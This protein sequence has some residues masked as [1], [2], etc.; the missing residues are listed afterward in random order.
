MVPC[1]VT[2]LYEP[3]ALSTDHPLLNSS[4]RSRKTIR[5]IHWAPCPFSQGRTNT[6]RSPKEPNPTKFNS[7]AFPPFSF[8]SERL[9]STMKE[10]MNVCNWDTV[11][12]DTEGVRE[13]ERAEDDAAEALAKAVFP[14]IKRLPVSPHTAMAWRQG[15]AS[16]PLSAP[17]RSSS[18]HL[19][20]S[21]TL[22]PSIR[23]PAPLSS[24]LPPAVLL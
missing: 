6:T 19:A 22:S 13:G 21:C 3:G 11:G 15:V 1:N 7:G 16:L 9:I 10:D 5:C 23:P 20:G 8:R 14:D 4:S 12:K 18:F 2:S 24:S 17:S